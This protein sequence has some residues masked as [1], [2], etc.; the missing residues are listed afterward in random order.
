MDQ[1]FLSMQNLFR[2]LNNQGIDLKTFNF[3]QACKTR[4]TEICINII[5]LLHETYTNLDRLAVQFLLQPR[6]RAPSCPQAF[7]DI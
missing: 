5:R 2:R 1:S 3:S 6:E 4:D 7:S